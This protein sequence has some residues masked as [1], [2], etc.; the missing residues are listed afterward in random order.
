MKV[1][2]NVFNIFPKTM[3]V[4]GDRKIAS[5]KWLG[6][7]ISSPENRLIMGATAIFSQPFIDIHNKDV[8]KDTRKASFARTAAKIVAGT[9]T[10]VSIRYAT[11]AIIK[12][13]SRL[14]DTSK[15]IKAIEK[16][17]V[18]KS[19]DA[20]KILNNPIAKSMYKDYQN[21]L[22]TILGL[23]VMIYTNFAWDVPLTRYFTKVF[24]KKINSPEKNGNTVSKGGQK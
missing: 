19:A 23:V 1:L 5:L 22:G 11:I 21:T 20:S 4:K 10:G 18:P 7:K 2:K 3:T 12:R 24:L 17:F 13:L 6:E 14:P 16:L 15:K 8:D 9:I